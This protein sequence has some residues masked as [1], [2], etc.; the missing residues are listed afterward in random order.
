M[1]STF[2]SSCSV[3]KLMFSTLELIFNKVS[4]C[5]LAFWVCQLRTDSKG[6]GG[7]RWPDEVI[8]EGTKGLDTTFRWESVWVS[9]GGKRKNSLKKWMKTSY[10]PVVVLE[11][12]LV[13]ES[14]ICNALQS[15]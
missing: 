5:A 2:V 12:G 10:K 8:G 9:K 3:R 1:E 6:L 14:Q 15:I 4:F 13:L 11:V 7:S